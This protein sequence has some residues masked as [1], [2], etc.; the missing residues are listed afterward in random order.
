MANR[1]DLT[2]LIVIGAL[3]VIVSAVGLVLGFHSNRLVPQVAAPPP[4]PDSGP[5][6]YGMRSMVSEPDRV[7]FEWGEQREATGYRVTVLSAAA[8]SLF[9]SPAVTTTYWTIPPDLRQRLHPQTAYRWRLTVE[10]E[11]RAPTTSEIA[12]FAT[13]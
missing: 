12:S 8:E 13:Q 4:V 2:S 7:R 5:I 9:T 1:R 3:A 10:Y 11:D 6:V